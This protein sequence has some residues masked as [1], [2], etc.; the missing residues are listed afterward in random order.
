MGSARVDLV[1]QKV[2]ASCWRP[3]EEQLGVF[4]ENQ[5][6]LPMDRYTVMK[7]KP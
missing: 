2:P 3:T 6:T 4:S 5:V 7:R 1:W